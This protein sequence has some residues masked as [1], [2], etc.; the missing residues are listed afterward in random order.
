MPQGTLSREIPIDPNAAAVLFIDV[1]NFNCRRD[2]GEYKGMDP[3]RREAEYGG[4]FRMLEER[5]LPN[6]QRLQAGCRAA[7]IE[8][9]YTVIEALTRDCRDMSLDYKITGFHVPRGSWDAKVLDELAQPTT[10]S[11]SPKRRHRSL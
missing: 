6:M 4:F 3:A 1:Q 8:V 5:A 9:M 2:G 10:R 11:S 7:G